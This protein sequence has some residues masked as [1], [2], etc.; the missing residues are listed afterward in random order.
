[1]AGWYVVHRLTFPSPDETGLLTLEGQTDPVT[2]YIDW[3]VSKRFGVMDI[4]I[5]HYITHE[6]VSTASSLSFS[7][8]LLKPRV[9]T[10]TRTRREQA[11]PSLQHRSKSSRASSGIIISSFSTTWMTYSSSEWATHALA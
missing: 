6:D 5:P 9:R 2:R 8:V 10:S 1:M 4:N 11:S 7:S 3:A